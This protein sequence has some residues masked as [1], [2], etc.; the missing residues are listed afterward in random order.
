M[1]ATPGTWRLL[2]AA[3]F[4]G[5]AVLRLLVVLVGGGIVRVRKSGHLVSSA[6]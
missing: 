1:Q 3:G 2:L 4:A 6:C 5:L